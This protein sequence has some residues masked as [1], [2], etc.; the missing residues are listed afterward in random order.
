MCIPAIIHATIRAMLSF[1]DEAEKDEE[2]KTEPKKKDSK[3]EPKKKDSKTQPKKKE[4][5]D[6]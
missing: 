1:S 5:S 6:S 4:Q 2:S 3:T